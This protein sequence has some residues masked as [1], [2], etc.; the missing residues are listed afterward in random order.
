[1]VNIIVPFY[2]SEAT[3]EET[4]A[5]VEA[6]TYTDW[7]VIFIDDG[8]T[9]SSTAIAQKFLAKNN[10]KGK[11]VQSLKPRSGPAK[12][13]NQAIQNADGLYIV[14]LDADD[15][16]APFC[17]E[18]RV[19]VM[20]KNPVLDWAVFN[21]Y[22]WHPG[23]KKPSRL[24]NL[25]AKTRQEA[26]DYFLKM[27]TTWQTMAPIWKTETIVK[28]GGF[29]DSLYPSEDPDIHLRALLDVN[30]NMEICAS[31]PP[32]CYYF[33]NNKSQDKMHGFY[34][35]SIKSKFRFLKSTIEYL[36]ATVSSEKL[37]TYK[38]Y[39]RIGYFKFM[40]VFLLSRFKEHA[41]QFAETTLLLKKT[42]ILSSRDVFKIKVIYF[43]FT[44]NS[45]IIKGLKLRGLT[46]FL[47]QK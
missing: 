37:K 27:E 29:N 44:N 3:L 33:V 17:L 24:F 4:L 31:L 1:M 2:N 8:S 40:R 45:F 11:L 20:E 26:I 22:E 14:C 38:Q 43:I 34:S 16:L 9:D 36:P 10:G 7:S 35:D 6:Q 28:L 15:R 5:S 18:Q 47:L 25:P 23:E 12:G 41:G 39:I 42:G 13:R 21:Q 32:D 46:K 30:L 19:A